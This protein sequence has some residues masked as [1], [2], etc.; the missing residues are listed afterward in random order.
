MRVD[1]RVD[2][3]FALGDQP[4][5]VFFGV[6]NVTNRTNVGSYQWNRRTNAEELGEQQGLFPILGLTYR[7]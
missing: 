7:F 2:R 5:V 6:Q 4:F 3:T 1:V